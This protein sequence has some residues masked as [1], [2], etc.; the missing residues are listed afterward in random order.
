MPDNGEL[1]PKDVP[2][3]SA[4][5]SPLSRRAFV[6]VMP[7]AAAILWPQ[8]EL[9]AR[10]SPVVQLT[11][12]GGAGNAQNYELRVFTRDE[13]TEIEAFTARIIPGDAVSPGA[14]EA[15]VVHFVDH[16]LSGAYGFQQSAYR[17]GLRHLDSSCRSRF[18]RQFRELSEK[19]QD[20]F[21]AKM[22]QQEIP[23]WSEAG[24]FFSMV[25]AHTI[26]GMFAD[27]KYHGNAGGVGWKLF[28]GAEH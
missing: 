13:A 9:G 26:E 17:E 20:Q 2:D 3:S 1:A 15:G 19:E 12:A 7:G 21:I 25:R 10:S 8:T 24:S 22:Q 28:S 18:Q 23:E 11:D 27:P 4:G 6:K 16:M 5:E 14:R